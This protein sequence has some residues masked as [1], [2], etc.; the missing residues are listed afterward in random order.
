MPKAAQIADFLSKGVLCSALFIAGIL[1]RTLGWN[2]SNAE[3]TL[4]AIIYEVFLIFQLG[5][6]SGLLWIQRAKDPKRRQRIVRV[7]ISLFI[8]V[9]I[10]LGNKLFELNSYGEIKV[11]V[12]SLTV[13]LIALPILSSISDLIARIT[14]KGAQK[15]SLPPALL[16]LLSLVAL[17]LT[18]SFLLLMPNCTTTES[19]PYIDALFTS[20]SAVCVTGLST[21]DF[22]HQFTPLGQFIVMILIQLGGFGIMTFAYF[23]TLVLGQGF[24]LRDKVLLR[25][26][27]DEDTLNS[28]TSFIRNIIVFTFSLELIGACFL[29]FSWKDMPSPDGNPIAWH[30]VFHAISAFCNA[31]FSTF[32]DG[33]CYVGVNTD[34]GAQT[35]IML[36]IISGGLGVLLHKEFF[37]HMK[38]KLSPKTRRRKWHWTTHFVLATRMTALLVFG[39][40]GLLFLIVMTSSGPAAQESWGTIMWE[41]LFTSVSSRTA[42]FQVNNLT[43]YTAPAALILCGLMMIGGSPGG[44]AG[45]LR[46]TTVATALGEIRRIIM[47]RKDVEFNNR[48]LDREVVERSIAAVALSGVWIGLFTVVSCYLQPEIDSLNLFFENVSAFSTTGLSRNVSPLL[49]TENKILIVINM[50]AGRV[51]LFSFMIALAG[52]PHPRYYQFPVTKLPLN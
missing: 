33:L 50:I 42:G 40:A 31:G 25:N 38:R 21:V 30:A 34:R 44:T 26:L 7:C 23:I 35:V 1:I 39:G 13:V 32:P 5:A 20:T 48:S 29:Y 14:G 18:G 6:L 16:F 36:L 37:V 46:T 11:I 10:H 3:L 51:G 24:S 22:A 17:L 47:G 8:L 45:G 15:A 52:K 4:Y 49:C 2:L 43:L 19:I 12:L 27:L 28:T 9:I 41:S